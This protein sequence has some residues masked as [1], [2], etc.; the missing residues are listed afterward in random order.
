MKVDAFD[1]VRKFEQAIAEYTGA[2]YVV[3]VNSC[4]MALLLALDWYRRSGARYVIIPYRTYPSV[5]MSAI[6]AGLTVEY[7]DK[8]WHGVYPL[9][10][11]PVWDCAKRF[12][13]GMYVSG[14]VQCVSFHAA[15]HLKIG[16][17]GAILHDN[18]MADSWY[19][20]ARFDG[21]TE[22][23]ATRDD[24]YDFAGWHCYMSPDAAAR[25][26]WLM[27]SY[28]ENVP[29]QEMHNYPDLR[30]ARL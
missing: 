10:P 15:K 14:Q 6:H 13:S 24:A 21:R 12:T 26:L 2:P 16:Q 22:G 29:D 25:G 3:A 9:L 28:P 19:R 1:I 27:Q 30:E 11:S 18:P 7:V 17:G 8:E 5:P 20:R 23:V 4:T